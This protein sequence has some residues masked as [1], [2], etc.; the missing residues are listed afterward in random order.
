MGNEKRKPGIVFVLTDD[1]GY[2]ELGCH[3]NPVIKTPN[4]DEF[5]KE[6]VRLTNYH[7][8]P[9]CAPT[10]AGLLT[11]HYA[12]STG[13]WHTVGGRSLLRKNEKS[14]ASIF[15]DAGYRTGIFGKWHLGDNY[16]F[17]PQDRGFETTVVHGGGGVSQTPDF[18][19]NDYYD[20]TYS[21]NG[22]LKKFDGYCTDVWFREGMKFIE[23]NKD[24]P[25][26][27]YIP[28]NAPHGP[29]NVPKKYSD[30]YR[31]ADI[32][33]KRK[34]FYGMITNID[35][36]FGILKKKIQELGI[37]ENTILIFMT[38]NGTSGGCSR[39]KNGFVTEG[40]NAGMRG[41]KGSEYE[42]GHR[43]PFFIRLP[44]GGLAQG[45]DVKE[46]TA[47]VDILPTLMDLCG[48][49]IGN[50]P[51]FDGISIA[52]LLHGGNEN[53]EDRAV[54]TDS[55]RIVYPV[56]WKQS[57]T[58]T[59][60]WRLINGK[61]LYDINA[62]PE[63]RNDIADQHADVVEKLRKEYEKWWDRVSLQF[64][65]EIPIA[66]G[67]D[68]EK[69]ARLT[70]HDMRNEGCNPA[71][72]Q[73]MVRKGHVDNGYWEIEITRAGK[74]M[75]EL[76]RWPKE[77]DATLTQGLETVDLKDREHIEEKAYWWYTGGCAIPITSAKIRV[78]EQEQSK[79]VNAKDQNVVFTMELHPDQTHLQTWFYNEDGSSIGAYYVYVTY[80]AV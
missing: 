57:S 64:D 38:D 61:E 14:I 39:D 23:K 25:F 50:T 29:Y 33:D 35:E 9:T 51:D 58:M 45:F 69:V 71:W 18:W 63:Q 24:V 28:T 32:P 46:L 37:E 65:E 17:R 56:K 67:A 80:L 3:G 77:E 60:E 13:V 74:Y 66:L 41:V 78:G 49:P 2:G 20:D 8:G 43:V 59:Q 36:N 15:K 42:G 5:Y 53:W 62:D 12:N 4:I 16:P 47:N 72:H 70:A 19:G 6:S 21:I 75:F 40:Y 73:G 52:K 34:N 27:C 55:Q 1:Q 30:I 48:I 26:F 10:R 76:R 79:P 54:V 31:K 44:G 11:G 7:V 22:K 68:E